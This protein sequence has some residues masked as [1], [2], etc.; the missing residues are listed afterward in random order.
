[1]SVRFWDDVPGAGQYAGP[2]TIP[3]VGSGPLSLDL[4]D[5]TDFTDWTDCF[6]RVDNGYS[7]WLAG[8]IVTAVGY[9]RMKPA[10]PVTSDAGMGRIV[11]FI[12]PHVG[13]AGV[14]TP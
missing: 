3:K 2:L 13:V 12:A 1:V 7:G 8:G 5:D 9:R 11:Y 6:V 4:N 10:P 14:A